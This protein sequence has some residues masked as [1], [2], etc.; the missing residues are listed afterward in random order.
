MTPA[1]GWLAAGWTMIHFVWVGAVIALL[2]AIARRMLRNAAVEL[3]YTVALAG[4]ALL[5]LSPIAICWRVSRA[6][7][8]EHSFQA[9]ENAKPATPALREASEP[10]NLIGGDERPIGDR[11]AVRTIVGL[12]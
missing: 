1:D 10:R 8:V 7:K 6:I 9:T 5:A 2:V 4:L 12:D 3:R 11:S